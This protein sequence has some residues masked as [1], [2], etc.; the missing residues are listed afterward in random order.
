MDIGNLV[1]SFFN[2]PGPGG[3]VVMIVL[4]GAI[5]FYIYLTRWILAGGKTNKRG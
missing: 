5:G 2:N 4:F 1:Y 3:A